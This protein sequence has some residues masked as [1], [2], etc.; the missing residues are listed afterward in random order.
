MLHN[1]LKK[2]TV[3][4][5]DVCTIV[6]SIVTWNIFNTLKQYTLRKSLF[7]KAKSMQGVIFSQVY[8][9]YFKRKL[10]Y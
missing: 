6:F 3:M 2:T 7:I 9:S 1:V 8:Y 4:Y 5:A 10:K